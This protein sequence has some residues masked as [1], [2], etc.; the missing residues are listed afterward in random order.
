MPIYKAREDKKYKIMLGNKKVS[1]SYFWLGPTLPRSVFLVIQI[2]V[3]FRL[4]FVLANSI[5]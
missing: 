2:N 1:R 4:R 5:V 3:Y